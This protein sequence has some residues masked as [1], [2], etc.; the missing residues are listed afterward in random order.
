MEIVN[1][2]VEF[3]QGWGTVSAMV[4]HSMPVIHATIMRVNRFFS[5]GYFLDYSDEDSSPAILFKS[6]GTCG[7]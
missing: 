3:L 4:L 6:C 2:I 7:F 5:I 1:C